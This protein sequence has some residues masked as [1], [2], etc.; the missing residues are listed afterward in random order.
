MRTDGKLV[1]CIRQRSRDSDRSRN[2]TDRDGKEIQ[3]VRLLSKGY[4]LHALPLVLIFRGIE[5]SNNSKPWKPV[6][7]IRNDFTS[8]KRVILSF[9]SYRP[10]IKSSVS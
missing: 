2:A 1:R 7:S 8:I 9:P 3:N 5:I 4:A 10:K 6:P